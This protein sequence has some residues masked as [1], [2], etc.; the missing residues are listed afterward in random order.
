MMDLALNP[1]D[2]LDPASMTQTAATYADR[3]ARRRQRALGGIGGK[4]LL[5]GAAAKAAPK[6]NLPEGQP[7]GAS[8]TKVKTAQKLG[9]VKVKPNQMFGGCGL[10]PDGSYG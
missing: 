8:P 3:S 10:R 7:F 6:N 9:Q 5:Q 1:W 2:L 4:G